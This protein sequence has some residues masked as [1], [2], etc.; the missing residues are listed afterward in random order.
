MTSLLLSLALSISLSATQIF[1][2]TWS[3]NGSTQATIT[4]PNKSTV[5]TGWRYPIAN[6]L[7]DEWPQRWSCRVPRLSYFQETWGGKYMFPY[8]GL[9]EACVIQ[10]HAIACVK[11]EVRE[12]SGR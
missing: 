1:Q 4:L 6:L 9:Y 2:Y 8:V 11:F 12:G 10:D 5:C 7:Q 3:E